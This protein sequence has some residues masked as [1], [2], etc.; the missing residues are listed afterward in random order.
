[1]K[2]TKKTSYLSAIKNT[3]SKYRISI[4]QSNH[5]DQTIL[6]PYYKEIIDK[7]EQPK[8]QSAPF[9]INPKFE[10]ELFQVNPMNE[11]EIKSMKNKYKGTYDHL[12]GILQH[13]AIMSQ[14]DSACAIVYLSGY[15]LARKLPYY[16]VLRY[17]M[18]YLFRH[19]HVPIMYSR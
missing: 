19:P 5:I 11:K 16:I 14:I 8:F 18:R 3:L 17:F 13:L 1:M 9:P 6:K 2:R 7:K 12:T 10:V 4:D 15:N